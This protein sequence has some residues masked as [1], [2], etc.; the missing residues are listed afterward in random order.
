MVLCFGKQ[1]NKK[2]SWLGGDT[3]DLY[4]WLILIGVLIAV[5]LLK[6]VL[7]KKYNQKKNSNN[8]PKDYEDDKM[9]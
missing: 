6:I 9:Y 2:I 7:M 4:W 1:V 3:Y 8:R 5:G